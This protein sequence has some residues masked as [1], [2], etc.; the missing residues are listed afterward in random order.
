MSST[1][2]PVGKGA[3]GTRARSIARKLAMQALYQWQLTQQSAAEIGKQ[4]LE[5][6]E[7]AGVDREH[8]EEL[9]V[10]SIAQHEEL[11]TALAPYLDRPLDQLD[12]VETAILLIGMYELRERLDIPYRVVINEAVD[13]CKRFGATDAHKYVNA[14]LDRAARELRAAERG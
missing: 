1:G 12:P 13:L 5:S 6:E 3:R 4:F 10:K 7:S 8:F 9:V 11:E 2:K 14:V